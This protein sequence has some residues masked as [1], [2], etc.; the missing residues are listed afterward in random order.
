MERKNKHV[1]SEIF[2]FLQLKTRKK[3]EFVFDKTSSSLTPY[4]SQIAQEYALRVTLCN[5]ISKFREALLPSTTRKKLRFK[6]EKWVCKFFV[7]SQVNFFMRF[8]LFQKSEK[9]HLHHEK[10]LQEVARSFWACFR[11]YSDFFNFSQKNLN[12]S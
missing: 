11:T 9:L 8:Q 7:A 10:S 4:Y 1:D 5:P 3:S 6:G 12:F 2:H